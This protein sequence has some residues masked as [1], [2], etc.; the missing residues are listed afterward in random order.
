MQLDEVEVVD[1]FVF[2]NLVDEPDEGAFAQAERLRPYDD[3]A[4]GRHVADELVES[5]H[6]RVGDG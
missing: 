1:A 3:R 5:F 2:L 6:N 4:P